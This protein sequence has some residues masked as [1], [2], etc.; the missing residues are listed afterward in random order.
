MPRASRRRARRVGGALRGLAHGIATHAP[1]YAAPP[2]PD[3]DQFIK[4]RVESVLG[5]YPNLPLDHV[6]FDAV[7]GFVRVRGEV[8]DEGCA[9]EILA[10]VAAV[11]GVRAAF[12]LMHS[13]DGVPVGG[14]A[15]DAAAIPDEP[16]AAVYAQAVRRSLFERW[17]ALTDADILA[18]DGHVGRLAE[19]I[20]SRTGQQPAEVRP[21]LDAILQA[22]T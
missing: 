6:V 3:D 12:S 8:P 7:D 4:Q 14:V 2:P 11:P 5:R 16:R 9:E 20:S 17:P 19:R 13:P 22:A 21:V 10:R 18:S 1:W 15:G